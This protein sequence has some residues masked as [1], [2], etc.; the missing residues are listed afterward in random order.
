MEKYGKVFKIIR[1]SKKMSLKEVAGEFVTPAQLSRFENGKSNL[2]VDTFFNCLKRMDILQGEFLTFYNVY[3][4]DED[5]RTSLETY[6]A[7]EMK[8]TS[9]FKK[10]IQEYEIKYELE[11]RKSDRVLIAV[12]HVMMHRC[13]SNQKIPNIEQEVIADYLLSIDEWCL[14]EIW[15]FGYCAR[16]LNSKT[17]E[18]LC[19]ELIGRTQFYHEIGE[20]L[21]RVYGVL[22]NAVGYL[23]DRGEEKIATKVIRSIESLG[24][25]E[26]DLF[27]RLQLT[28]F[29]SQLKFLQGDIKGLDTM[30]QLL[31]FTK[32]L[33]CYNAAK[34]IE[35]TIL[36][37]TDM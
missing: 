36:R 31:E 17:L 13:D 14:Y 29:K 16:C 28:F 10:K 4:Q 7:L 35:D 12:F 1:K 37:I 8:N 2:S 33:D 32:L 26:G 18:V 9:Y 19:S 30:K 5:V 23:L 15:I 6:T 11:G 3:Y 34:D 24:I 25:H 21:K 20:N 22:L 27:E